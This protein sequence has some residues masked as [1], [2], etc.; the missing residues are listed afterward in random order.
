MLIG[1]VVLIS[2]GLWAGAAAALHAAWSVAGELAHATS[3]AA[4]GSHPQATVVYDRHQ[5]P[6]FT[7]FVEQRLDVPLDRVSPHMIQALLA[8]EDR[9]FF[10]HNGLDPLRIV[11]AAWRNWQRGR[12]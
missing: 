1:T 10:N 4:I 2:A 9:R 11:K 3:L 7:F 5:R 8:V 12:I 6:A